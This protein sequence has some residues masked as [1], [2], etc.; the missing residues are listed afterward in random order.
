VVG[1][2]EGADP[3][4]KA[5][6]LLTAHLI[7]LGSTMSTPRKASIASTTARSTTLGHRHP[8]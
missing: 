5:Q 2:I 1:L 4:L 6:I 7:T 8:C 3:K